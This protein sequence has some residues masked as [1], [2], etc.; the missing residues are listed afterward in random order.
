MHLRGVRRTVAKPTDTLTFHACPVGAAAAAAA[1][2]VAVLAVAV[3]TTARRVSRM[4]YQKKKRCI[5][6]TRAAC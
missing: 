1:A 4:P 5:T 3:A 2:A 6:T